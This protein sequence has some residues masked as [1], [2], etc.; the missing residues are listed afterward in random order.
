MIWGLAFDQV[1]ALLGLL[2][3][4]SV[5]ASK[6]SAK[7]G[8]P[9]LVLFILL[10]M[11][12]GAEGP[13]GLQFKDYKFAQLLGELALALIIFSG[14]LDTNW[15]SVKPL[16]WRALSLSTIGVAITCGLVAIFAVYLLNFSI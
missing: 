6:A 5:L 15:D 9:A 13:G 7:L 12:A 10:G 14:G 8:V 16:I 2:L 4:A 11:L 1:L 3:L